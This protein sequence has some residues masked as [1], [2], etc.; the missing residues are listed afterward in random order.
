MRSHL[1]FSETIKILIKKCRKVDYFDTQ[2][3]QQTIV[4]SHNLLESNFKDAR[5]KWIKK[6]CLFQYNPVE[7]Q[8]I[9]TSF[10]VL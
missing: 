7:Y 4:F 6:I 10:S 3:D 9:F 8:A 1:G 5:S 2:D